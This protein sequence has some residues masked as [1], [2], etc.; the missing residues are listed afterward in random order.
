MPLPPLPD[1]NTDRAWLKYTAD[2]I[3]H[4]IVVRFPSA[5]AQATIVT[6]M[7]TLANGL[8]GFIRTTDSF[9]ALRHQDSGSTLSFPL[10]WTAIAG[11]N[12]A[13]PDA[14]NKPAYLSIVGRSLGGYRCRMT[15]FCP[16]GA[17]TLLYRINRVS[18]NGADTFLDAVEAMTP[19]PVAKDG[20]NVVWNQYAN[21][22]YNA[23]WQRQQ[24]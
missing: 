19:A 18:G 23:Y 17:D 7:T 11:T 4:E 24:R 9:T 6:A 14:D 16:T 15:M 22:G 12:P 3:E 20:Q 2:G 13:V 10:D 5:T 1:N 8:K 21:R